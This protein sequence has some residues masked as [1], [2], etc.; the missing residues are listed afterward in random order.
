MENEYK[1][2][3]QEK[4]EFSTEQRAYSEKIEGKPIGAMKD[5]MMRFAKNK[6]ALVAFIMLTILLLFTIFG[7]IVVKY[8]YQ[9]VSSGRYLTPKVQLVEKLGFLDGMDEKEF[10]IYDYDQFIAHVE[11]IYNSNKPSNKNIIYTVKMG[12]DNIPKTIKR[13]DASPEASGLTLDEL[14]A[15]MS[16]NPDIQF[17]FDKGVGR[18]TDYSDKAVENQTVVEADITDAETNAK[19]EIHSVEYDTYLYNGLTEDD[20]H[21]FGTDG[22]GRDYFARCWMAT[23]LSL[24]IGLIAATF[25]LIVGLIYGAISGYYGGTT[26]MIMQRVLEILGGVPWFVVFMI[27]VAR[28]GQSMWAI[29]I[30]FVI[31]GWIGISR[32][33]RMQ[34]LRYRN[35]EYVLA[36]RSFGVN[37]KKLMFRHILPNGIG[38]LITTTILIIPLTIFGESSFAVLG[39][40]IEG[41]ISLGTLL[42]DGRVALNPLEPYFHVTFFPA[43]IISILMLS[44]NMIGNGLRDAFNPALRGT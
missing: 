37:D 2:I 22:S 5:A 24:L 16:A 15:D 32:V 3:P 28:F 44:F 36:A 29:L 39:L 42:N 4:F 18:F 31:T 20:Y 40:G 35:R 21:W 23:R 14:K 6:A 34:F 10:Y 19:Y 43:I 33:T 9:A 1:D 25:N 11:G 26:D 38:T 17:M 27:M 30:A 41:K 12:E 13:D 7:P 8:D